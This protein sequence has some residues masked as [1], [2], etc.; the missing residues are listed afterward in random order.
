MKDD[1]LA[2][3]PDVPRG[4][5]PTSAPGGLGGRSLEAHEAV[6]RKSGE[7]D[8]RPLDFGFF[9][10]PSTS[11]S[12]S[13]PP[14][15]DSGSGLAPLSLSLIDPPRLLYERA[16]EPSE[17]SPILYRERAYLV[18]ALQSDEELEEQL[19]AELAAIREELSDRD[20]PQYVQ[21]ALFDH[22]FEG[23]PSAPPVATLSWKDWQGRSE[24]WVRG[25]RRSS[26][27]PADA[28]AEQ[29]R[30]NKRLEASD[31]DDGLEPA[32]ESL[33]LGSAPRDEENVV[34]SERD[35]A[36]DEAPKKRTDSGPSWQAPSRSGEYRIPEALEEKT[37]PPS[38]QRVL[39]AEELL[40]VLFERMQELTYEGNIAGG[41][42]FVRD[43]IA[44]HI[45][46]DG[47][48]IHVVDADAHE[49]VVVRALGPSGRD[50]VGLRTALAGS[51][52][53][54]ALRL[55]TTLELAPVEAPSCAALWRAL[56]VDAALILCVPVQQ[57][58]RKLGAIEVGRLTSGARFSDAERQALRYIAEQF[59]D[60]VAE[61]PLLLDADALA[62]P[63]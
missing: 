36:S 40:G 37:S 26:A 8:A 23:Q 18:D 41:A 45:V 17:E 34:T 44:E 51:H 49:L 30:S 58:Q 53:G 54:E 14:L 15:D 47:A 38:S 25:V 62:P 35:A 22:E 4:N 48:L 42:A 10:T 59:A 39:A 56:G 60:F 24:V 5:E 13:E 1:E 27:P 32:S 7:A 63:P 43:V 28:G 19:Q 46:C 31:D 9:D 52:L 12:P 3:S 33:P 6:G 2:N 21:L 57:E 55:E 50:T 16:H 20:A 29:S 61:R 11:R